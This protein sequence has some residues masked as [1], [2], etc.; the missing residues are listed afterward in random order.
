MELVVDRERVGELELAGLDLVVEFDHD[1]HLHGAG[2]VKR[3][4]SVVEPFGFAIEGAKRYA[5]VGV[6]IGDAFLDLFLGGDEAGGLRERGSR[7][8]CDDG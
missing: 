8:E 5:D 2:G 3:V 1:G 6:R 4:I 7:H